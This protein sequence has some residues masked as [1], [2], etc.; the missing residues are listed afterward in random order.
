MLC[1]AKRVLDI[2]ENID[3]CVY[4]TAHLNHPCTIWVRESFANYSWVL[5]LVEAMHNEWKYRYGHDDTVFH[6][7]YIVSMYLRR[8]PPPLE[9]FEKQGMTPFALAMPEIYKDPC[10]PVKS[11]RDYYQSPEKQ[12]IASWKRRDVPEW[13]KIVVSTQPPRQIKKVVKNPEP[14]ITLR[15]NIMGS[16][17]TI[18]EYFEMRARIFKY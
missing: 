4:K 12:R 15:I 13:Y 2:E 5:D 18:K 1:T 8:N 17:I 10:D 7:S 9:A 14:L 6:K 3:S 11:Y 16:Q